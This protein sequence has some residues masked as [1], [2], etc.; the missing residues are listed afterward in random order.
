MMKEK[1]KISSLGFFGIFLSLSLLFLL[2]L[3]LFYLKPSPPEP[4]T[5]PKTTPKGLGEVSQKK[6]PVKLTLVP[7]EA[8]VSPGE[9]LE[10]QVLAQTL[11]KLIA[12]DLELS[13]DPQVFQLL[14][15][16]PGPFWPKP[17][18]L[19]KVVDNIKGELLYGIATLEPKEGGGVITSLKFKPKKI[20]TLPFSTQI[21]FGEGTQVSVVG[22]ETEMELSPPGKYV[23][24]KER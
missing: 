4:E 15:V 6:T 22:K 12:T 16:K 9:I 11:G 13:F 8:Q 19:T 18:Q 21:T 5:L 23:I 1:V 24:L 10:I 2:I 20:P 3:N 14:E 7:Q 17:Q